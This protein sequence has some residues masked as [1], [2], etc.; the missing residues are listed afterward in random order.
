[1]TLKGILSILLLAAFISSNE[2]IILKGIVTNDACDSGI[3]KN[4]CKLFTNDRLT[5]GPYGTTTDDN[6]R[7]SIELPSNYLPG[8]EVIIDVQVSGYSI[9]TPTNGLINLPNA[10]TQSYFFQKIVLL[11][12]G[13]YK[14]LTSD[15]LLALIGD[16]SQR[17]AKKYNAT[18]KTDLAP[19]I[20]EFALQ[21]GFSEQQVIAALDNWA[22]A[23]NDIR[24]MNDFTLQ[25][26]KNYYRKQYRQAAINYE[27]AAGVEKRSLET[28]IRESEKIH[29]NIVTKFDSL[30]ITYELAANSALHASEFENARR[31]YDSANVNFHRGVNLS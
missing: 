2:Q 19:Y 24:E 10:I 31:L 11:P 21:H 3:H 29:Q 17:E 18:K 20:Q 7:F 28:D 23:N 13:D 12:R 30:V 8:S 4:G 27:K 26:A 22:T 6:G 5:V 9:L 14:F 16:I 1:M 15:Q 25:G